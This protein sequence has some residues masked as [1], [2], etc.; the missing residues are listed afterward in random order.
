[1]I[2]TGILSI[3]ILLLKTI[4]ETKIT[5]KKRTFLNSLIFNK[6]KVERKMRKITKMFPFGKYR[7]IHLILQFLHRIK[8]KWIP[9]QEFNK[10]K[11]QKWY[12]Y[13]I[14]LMTRKTS[15]SHLVDLIQSSSSSN[16]RTKFRRQLSLIL[17]NNKITNKAMD[18]SSKILQE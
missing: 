18:T 2:R 6:K 13:R 16:Q 10:I 8:Y 12:P 14:I 5:S 15:K 7:I 1:M 3:I 17:K 9:T 11:L 4:K